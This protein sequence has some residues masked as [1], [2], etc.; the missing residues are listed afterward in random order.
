[1][2]NN[3]SAGIEDSVQSTFGAG[4][5]RGLNE[6]V[7]GVVG[8]VDFG[9]CFEI[10]VFFVKV[11]VLFVLAFQISNQFHALLAESIVMPG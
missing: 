5:E 8:K 4:E 2:A 6:V 7:D 3:K 11:L 10:D 9:Y 1:M